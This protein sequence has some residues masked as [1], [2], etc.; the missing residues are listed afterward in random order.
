VLIVCAAGSSAGRAC[1]DACGLGPGVIEEL[2]WYFKIFGML[3]EVRCRAEMAELM[4]RH[5]NTDVPRKGVGDLLRY[6][7][8]ALPTAALGD[9]EM[10]IHV[11][12]EVRQHVATIPSKATSNFVRNL[13][14][15]VFSFA[16]GVPGSNVKDYLTTW[17]IRFV[18]VVLP[19]KGA[20]V[21]RPKRQGEQ[22]IDRDR[23]LG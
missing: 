18:E 10:A 9:E 2:P 3:L 22:D 4:R 7:R 1:I 5:V 12:A 21:L 19:V 16:L 14:G 8:L 11:G 15:N 20:K 13:P 23:N 17:T 6:G